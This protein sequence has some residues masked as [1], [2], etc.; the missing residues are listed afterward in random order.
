MLCCSL[1]SGTNGARC[2]WSTVPAWNGLRALRRRGIMVR[3][4]SAAARG[5][6][7]QFAHNITEMLSRFIAD[8]GI[9]CL[10][11]SVLCTVVGIVIHG[12]GM[13]NCAQL[14]RAG[15]LRA[16]A[17]WWPVSVPGTVTSS[18]PPSSRPWAREL[19]IRG[20]VFR[21][22]RAPYAAPPMLSLPL[23]RD[24]RCCIQPYESSRVEPSLVSQVRS[25]PPICDSS[26][27]PSVSGCSTRTPSQSQAETTDALDRIAVRSARRATSHRGQVGRTH[28][29][30]LTGGALAL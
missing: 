12:Q 7:R 20:R 29:S 27:R 30:G 18:T 13:W 22:C 21:I 1:G 14:P 8:P 25:G 26:P 11:D 23:A 16:R 19:R 28:A 5:P 15:F 17:G 24:S 2:L 3:I 9:L 10:V 6:C 4:A